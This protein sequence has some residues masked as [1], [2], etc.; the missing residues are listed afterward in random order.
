MF[1]YR[2][3]KLPFPGFEVGLSQAELDAMRIESHPRSGRLRH[4]GPLL[5]LSE[6]P[7]R[8]VLPTPELGSHAPEWPEA[9]SRAAAE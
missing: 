1:V 9:G 7:P 8:W 3:G 4:L 6:T 5:K 2:Q